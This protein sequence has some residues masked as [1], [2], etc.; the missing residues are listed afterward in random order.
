MLK[1]VLFAA[2]LTILVPVGKEV[3]FVV[4]VHVAVAAYVGGRC[5]RCDHLLVLLR[6]QIDEFR[7]WTTWAPEGPGWGDVERWG[8]GADAD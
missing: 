2:R 1:P 4:G 7:W 8:G 5:G 6:G 3:V